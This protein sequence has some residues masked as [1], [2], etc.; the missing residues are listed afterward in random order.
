MTAAAIRNGQGERAT[1]ADLAAGLAGLK[2]SKR[3]TC[4]P[5]ERKRFTGMFGHFGT[6]DDIAEAAE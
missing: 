2:T 4:R 6:A 3:K 1:R 5:P